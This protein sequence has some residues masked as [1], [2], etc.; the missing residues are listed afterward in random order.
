MVQVLL[1]HV[2]HVHAV[3]DDQHVSRDRPAQTPDHICVM[4]AEGVVP[5]LFA[6]LSPDDQLAI[7]VINSSSQTDATA[8]RDDVRRNADKGRP[9]HVSHGIRVSAQLGFDFPGVGRRADTLQDV[10]EGV[11][12][13]H[14]QLQNRTTLLCVWLKGRP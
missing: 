11:A 10:D 6:L 3:G 8:G 14:R 7:L 2:H 1:P 5:G 13:G 12:S 9:R 4:V